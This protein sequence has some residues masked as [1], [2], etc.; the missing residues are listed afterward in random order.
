MLFFYW[1]S[2][3]LPSVSSDSTDDS[4]QIKTTSSDQ[5]MDVLETENV[6]L[7]CRFDPGEVLRGGSP[8]FFWIRTN[9]NGHDNVAIGETQLENNYS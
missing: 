7:E 2:G 6:L 8:L 1:I 5:T 4:S 3:L 9:R